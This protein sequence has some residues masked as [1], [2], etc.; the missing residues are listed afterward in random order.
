[1][2]IKALFTALTLASTPIAASATEVLTFGIVP[3]QSASRLAQ[4]W[5]P[6]LTELGERTGLEVR[7]R[8]TKDIPTFEACLNE[9]AFDIAYMNPMHYAVFSENGGYRAILR[10]SGK[11][12]KGLVVARA[13]GARTLADLDGKQVAFPSPGAFGA[14][15][16]TRARLQQEGVAFDPAYVKSHDSVYRAVAAGL[17]DGGGGVLRTFNAVDPQIRAQLTIIHE[18]DAFTPHAIALHAG[19]PADLGAT[20]KA[21]LTDIAAERPE[22]V[23]N[24]G[25]AGLQDSSDADWDDVRALN[26]SPQDTGILSDGSVSC[27]SD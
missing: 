9:G 13:D 7:F 20:L 27:P 22:L 11:R 25:M 21:T 2:R 14:S 18:T 26:M 3:Q 1:M 17:M 8:T 12:L 15:V 10:Q 23:E 6:L 16:L 4:M 5:G 24:I 19:V